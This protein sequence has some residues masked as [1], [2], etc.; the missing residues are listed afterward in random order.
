MNFSSPFLNEVRVREEYCLFLLVPSWS[1]TQ[2][3]RTWSSPK[4][5]FRMLMNSH[6][7]KPAK[8]TIRVANFRLGGAF[9]EAK[10]FSPISTVIAAR[11]FF[12]WF[13]GAPPLYSKPSQARRRSGS[14]AHGARDIAFC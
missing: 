4:L 1:S 9:D 2:I 8:S 13:R 6:F 12:S 10:A 3:L 14:S 5:P 7:L 11:G